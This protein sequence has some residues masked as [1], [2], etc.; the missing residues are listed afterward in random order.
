LLNAISNTIGD[1]GITPYVY[2]T[3]APVGDKPT[4]V[5]IT[6]SGTNLG[7]VTLPSNAMVVEYN[8]SV[9][10]VIYGGAAP[11]QLVVAGNSGITYFANAGIGTVI[12]GGG[13]NIIRID[14][15][16]SHHISTDAGADWI[17]VSSGDNF[18]SAGLGKN[19]IGLDSGNNTVD[20][21]G[22]DTVSIGKGNDTITV[23]QGGKANITGGSGKLYVLNNGGNATVFAGAGSTTVDGASGGGEYW[24]GKG[25]NN[26]LTGGML[27]TTLYGGGNGDTLTSGFKNDLLV[28]GPGNETLLGSGAGNVTFRTGSGDD[29]VVAGAGNDTIQDGSGNATLWGGGGKDSFVFKFGTAG[30]ITEIKDFTFGT[31]N[32]V[33][34][35]YSNQHEFSDAVKNHATIVPAT[36]VTAGSITVT[37]SD[38]TTIVFDGATV[39]TQLV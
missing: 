11:D 39:K 2:G 28:A 5:L 33:L 27:Q 4:G 25:G 1:G 14:K 35:G 8:A 32:I 29:Y 6:G 22:D 21:T 19:L 10:G 30:G 37:L 24:G 13:D 17:T 3:P 20:V 16:S 23:E 34:Q 7:S 15:G 26:S 18:I 31:D 38:N 12:A 9:R 36:G